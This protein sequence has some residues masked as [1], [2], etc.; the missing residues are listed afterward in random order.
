MPGHLWGLLGAVL[1]RATTAA[2]ESADAGVQRVERMACGFRSRER[3]RRANHIHLGGL[4][5]CP[6]LP[7]A[8]HTGS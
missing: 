4:D 2:L 7:D 3:F 8:T 1:L 6:A 5:L